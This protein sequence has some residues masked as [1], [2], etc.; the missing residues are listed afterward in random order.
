MS[1]FSLAV[2]PSLEKGLDQSLSMPS[3]SHVVKYFDYMADLLRMGSP[4][5][6][7]LGD[8]MDFN[9]RSIQNLICGGMACNEDSLITKL[10]SPSNYPD[11]L[12]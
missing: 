12:V 10:Y 4:V 8:G 1:C 3:D 11:M 6:W 9:N 2:I 5:Y 7:V